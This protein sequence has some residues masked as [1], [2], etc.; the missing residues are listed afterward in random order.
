MENLPVVNRN[1]EIVCPIYTNK[2]NYGFAIILPKFT[3]LFR[4]KLP[5]IHHV[6]ISMFVIWLDTQLHS[7]FKLIISEFLT[8]IDLRNWII[9]RA[10]LLIKPRKNLYC[11]L[12]KKECTT[13]VKYD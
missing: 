1:I 8:G 10:D 5:V 7:V 11:S 2:F 12:N 6:Q 4:D 3:V 9:C 13:Q